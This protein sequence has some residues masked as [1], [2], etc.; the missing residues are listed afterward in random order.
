MNKHTRGT[1]ARLL[2][3]L[4]AL[5]PSATAGRADDFD[6]APIN[7][8]TAKPDNVVSRLQA[9]LDAGQARLPYDEDM[10]YLRSVL[11]ELHV[12]VSSQMLVFSKTS[13]QRNRISPQTPRALY[14]NDDVYVGYCKDGEVME[15]S[16]ADPQL[17]TVF[18]TLEQAPASKPRIARQTDTCLLCHGSSSTGGVPGHL[19]RSVFPDS[20]G[21]PILA[22]GTYRI[23]H[24]SPLE[25]RWGGWYVT[26]KTG[27]QTHLGNLIV[28]SR[29]VELPVD[30]SAGVNLTDLGDRF[31]R[32]RYLS[33]HSDVVA[34]MVL[35][36][37]A[38]MH[39]RITRASFTARQALHQEAVLN[40]EM[41][42]PPGYRWD[43]TT[44]RIRSAGDDLVKYLLFSEE[45]ALTDAVRGTSSFAAD[46][47]KHGPRDHLGRS[48]RDFDLKRR[49][50]K[51]PCSY[52]IYSPSFDAL[53][54]EMR[55][56]VWQ[57][58][59]EVLSGRDQGKDFAHL[60]KQDRQAIREILLETK[61]GLP[62]Y[63]KADPGKH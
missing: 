19:V 52:L 32:K 14:F 21:L 55:T 34:L 39:N 22:S 5:V 60:S 59:H 58:L 45:A 11:R 38:E 48:L 8:S 20:R 16:V 49:L 31:D 10:G 43:S 44:V 26:G 61:P 37:Q 3:V 57:R 56:Y 23:D 1:R 36:H 27:A 24:T 25:R 40:R 42:S 2:A 28:R 15:L 63:W 53:P 17:G 62:A 18:C 46:F 30:N 50:F 33:G 51:Y 29:R 6:R 9:R 47:A 12:P 41:K 35:E 13:L 7:Y 4:L 54:A